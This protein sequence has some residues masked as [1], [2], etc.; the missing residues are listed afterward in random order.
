[1]VLDGKLERIVR[2]LH[3][4]DHQAKQLV[5]KDKRPFPLSL[6]VNFYSQS[7]HSSP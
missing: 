4:Y 5:S 1:M 6:L 3:L 2:L 7:E